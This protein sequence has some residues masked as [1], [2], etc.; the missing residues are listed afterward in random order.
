MR[1]DEILES[2]DVNDY[3]VLTDNGWVGIA[4]IN[5]T[6]EFDIYDLLTENNAQILCADKHIVFC[7]DN[8]E[9]YVVDLKPG[10]DEVI[11][12]QGLSKVKYVKK[13]NK[14]EYMYDLVLDETSI[15]QSYMAGMPGKLKIK[16]HNSTIYTV[17]ALHTAMFRKDTFFQSQ[18]EYRIV[19][20]REHITKGKIFIIHPFHARILPI[21][22]LVKE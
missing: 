7:K 6:I 14:K 2:Y 4:S 22:D 16:N 9:K 11:T 18:Q 1:E 8:E 13:L 10:I 15:D 5:K 19:L 17:F 21:D 3:E 20:P 12:E